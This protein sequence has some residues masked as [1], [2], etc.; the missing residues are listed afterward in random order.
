M[1]NTILMYET[2]C[3]HPQKIAGRIA[4]FEDFNTTSCRVYEYYDTIILSTPS[5][6]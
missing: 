4:L 2:L 1:E 6:N 3:G 5:S